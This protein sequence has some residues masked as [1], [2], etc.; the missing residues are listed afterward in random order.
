M[1]NRKQRRAFDRNKDKC[2]EKKAMDGIIE[3]FF[4]AVTEKT[5]ATPDGIS[6]DDYMAIYGDFET[7]WQK[8]SKKSIAGYREAFF[9]ESF[10]DAYFGIKTGEMTTEEAFDKCVDRYGV[11]TGYKQKPF[12]REKTATISKRE[13]AKLKRQEKKNG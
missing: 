3:R 10:K 4:I 13:R 8:A 6:H 12:V 7:E 2:I 11:I 5:I 9:R 1:M